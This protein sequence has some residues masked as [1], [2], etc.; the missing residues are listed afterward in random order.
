M[1]SYRSEARQQLFVVGRSALRL[2]LSALITGTT[3]ES[4]RFTT[5]SHGKPALQNNTSQLQFNLSHSHD[6]VVIAVTRGAAIGVDVEFMKARPTMADIAQH[7][8]HRQEWHSVKQAIES[9]DKRHALQQFY[10]VWALKEAFIKAEGR[11][12]AIPGD[13][14][15]FHPID[16]PSPAMALTDD[17]TTDATHWHFHHQFVDSQYSVALALNATGCEDKLIIKQRQLSPGLS[18]WAS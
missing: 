1:E 9:G 7:Y 18:V 12:M 10:K 4:L 17:I 6:A 15:Y 2:I 8:F 14:F 13:S 16:T 11:G 5:S 3:P